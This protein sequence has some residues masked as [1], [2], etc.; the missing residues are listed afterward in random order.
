MSLRDIHAW[1]ACLN[2]AEDW[3]WWSRGFSLFLLLV[4]GGVMFVGVGADGSKRGIEYLTYYLP[5]SVP[6]TREARC[7]FPGER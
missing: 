5:S 7:G 3:L 1:P 2:G 4:S 6:V